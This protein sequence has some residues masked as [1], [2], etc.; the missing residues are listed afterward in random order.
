MSTSVDCTTGKA[1]VDEM[2]A[3]YQSMP[4]NLQS[5]FQSAHDGIMSAFA[6]TWYVGIDL[7]P[8]NPSCGAIAQLGQQ[9]A[10]LTTQ[11]QTAM[12]QNPAT[13]PAIASEWSIGQ[14]VAA[15]TVGYFAIVFLGA[16]IK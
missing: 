11:M 2:D 7:I 10:T 16:K 5:S 13:P 1:L 14:I 6:S 9:A 8:F 12:G 15:V 4:T 3:V